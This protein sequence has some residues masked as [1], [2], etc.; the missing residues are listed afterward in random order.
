MCCVLE[1]IFSLRSSMTHM[2]EPHIFLIIDLKF[3]LDLL[4]LT[5]D[6][7]FKLDLWRNQY[8]KNVNY[9]YFF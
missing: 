3:K 9:N 7:E 6:L 5:I 2:E 8:K 4:F 1:N